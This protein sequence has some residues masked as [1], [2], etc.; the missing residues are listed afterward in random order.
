M[1]SLYWR[2]HTYWTGAGR[3]KD[4]SH[5]YQIVNVLVGLGWV[6]LG[7][8]GLGWVGLGCVALGWVGLGWVGLGW[9]GLVGWLVSLVGWLVSLVGWFLWLVGWLVGWFLW[10][11]GWFLWLVGW[12]VGFFG[13]LVG[14]F[15][16]LVGW[17]LWLVGWLVSLVGW[18]VSLVGCKSGLHLPEI[19]IAPPPLS[20][21]FLSSHVAYPGIMAGARSFFPS[22]DMTWWCKTTGTL[23]NFICLAAWFHKQS[24]VQRKSNWPK[25]I[26]V[27]VMENLYQYRHLTGTPVSSVTSKPW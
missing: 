24:N 10:L 7:W 1:V 11:V 13:W 2:C 23:G 22:Q 3:S 15:L 26:T 17:F 27:H 4:S 20:H 9:F 16:W 18:L 8:V 19:R 5:N 21:L 12:L 25:N 6:G 14:W